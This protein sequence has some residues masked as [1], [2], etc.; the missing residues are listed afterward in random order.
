MDGPT[1][2]EA[3]LRSELIL[4]LP[5]GTVLRTDAI[6]LSE[7]EIQLAR[8]AIGNLADPGTYDAIGEYLALTGRRSAAI[9]WLRAAV[10]AAPN[11]RLYRYHLAIALAHTGRT[12]AA[13]PHFTRAVGSAAAH[14]NLGVIAF[15]N[16][17]LGGSRRYFTEALRQHPGLGAAT[18]WLDRIDRDLAARTASRGTTTR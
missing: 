4:G 13:L 15:R 16:G 12:Q 5:A 9:P 1:L 6:E 8:I 3:A 11:E 18:V 10:E 17:D 2:G 14:Y 7:A